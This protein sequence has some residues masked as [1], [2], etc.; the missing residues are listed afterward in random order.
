MRSFGREPARRSVGV[1]SH[2]SGPRADSPGALTGLTGCIVPNAGSTVIS[3]ARARAPASPG[4]GGSPNHVQPGGSGLFCGCQSMH[5]RSWASLAELPTG[6]VEP[7][8]AQVGN[9]DGSDVTPVPGAVML[10]SQQLR[11]P[12]SSQ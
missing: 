3:L 7:P 10:P 4:S 12:C 6:L 5:G 11:R 2:S 1:A 8:D 9:D